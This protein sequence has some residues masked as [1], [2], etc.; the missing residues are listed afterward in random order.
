MKPFTK[1]EYFVTGVI[2]LFLVVITLLNLNIAVRRSRDVQRR[3]DLG[4]VAN[5][6]ETYNEDFGYFPPN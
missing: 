5:A 6:L 4:A 2:F 1:N 3:S